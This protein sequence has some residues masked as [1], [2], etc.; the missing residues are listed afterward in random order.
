[1]ENA[2][3][4][5]IQ[6]VEPTRPQR[7]R[8]APDRLGAVVGEWWKNNYASVAV[9]DVE[10]PKSINEAFNGKDSKH[11]KDATD[12]EFDSLIRNG[13]WELVELPEGKNVV[14]CKWVLKVKRKV[15][16]SIDRF[17]ARLVAQ[18]YTQEAG[19]DYDEI[20]A[21]VARY[22]SI[23]SVLAIANQFDWE[24]H[25]MDVKSA[26]LNGNLENEIYMNQPEGYID[27]EYPNMVCR[28]RKS[29]YG[30]KQSARCWNITMD[31]FL[32]SYGYV[33]ATADPCIYLKTEVSDEITKL[34]IIALYVDDCIL[35]SNDL[36]TLEEEKVSLSLK[37]EMDDR[38][39]IHYLLGM[40]IKRDRSTKILMINQKTYLEDILKRFGMYDSKPVSTPM[41]AGKKY[42]KLL[43]EEESV[44]LKEYQAAIGLLTYASI[45]TRPDLSYSVGVLSQFM[46][47]P[48]AEHW[49]AIKRIFRY[50]KGTL[51]YGLKFVS[52]D[53]EDFNLHGYADADW[54]GDL[55]TRKST[56]A[57]VFRL[58]DATISWSSKRQPVVALSSTEAEY[59]ALCLASQETIWLRTLLEKMNLKQSHATVVY[60]DNQGTMSLAKN[61]VHHSRTK[62][63]DIKFHFIR[64]TI[65]NNQVQLIYCP[66]ENMIA[67]VL[68]KG[69]SKP[70]FEELRSKMGVTY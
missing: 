55:T 36:R 25:Q 43:T 69:L 42:E 49:T 66:T 37:F 52:T 29:L 18:G 46:S 63:I 3:E 38:G 19:L 33:Q 50:I 2:T 58:G 56:S 6:L 26:F 12:S 54:A 59:I 31:T 61:P 1:M 17:K 62:H 23:R 35:T 57:Y 68:T 14:G 9:C 30:L 45:A 41:E 7:N 11:W 22:S 47:N 39:E 5:L 60:E 44:N 10:V 67:D 48:G 28:L 64:E 40:S 34:I 21:P 27:K 16:G 4:E 13:T 8:V 65:E 20:F 51:E 53:K 15:D 32:K 70:R 24:L